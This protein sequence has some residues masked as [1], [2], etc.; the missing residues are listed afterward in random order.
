MSL[1]ARDA[2]IMVDPA[3]HIRF[4]N[5]AASELFGWSREEAMG[6]DLHDTVTPE[7]QR[8]R[9]NESMAEFFRSGEISPSST[10]AE[11]IAMRKD[12]TTFPIELSL[13]AIRRDEGYWAVGIVRDMTR[14]KHMEEELRQLATTDPLTGLA[15][16]RS[17]MQ[18]A[19]REMEQCRRYGHPL[20]LLMLDIDH[21]KQVNDTWG[22]DAGDEVLRAV[23][24]I[25]AESIREVDLCGRL[26][27]EEFAVLLP[28]TPSERALVV[29]ERIR[30]SI[31][32]AIIRTDGVTIPI[33]LSVGKAEMAL[34]DDVNNVIRRADEALYKA[35][36][37][38]R[39]R[40]ESA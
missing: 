18:Q 27:G 36:R 34:D 4:W 7:T 5:P 11:R 22:H 2:I 6:R 17:F 19:E 35:K 20:C 16:R 38:G 1:A 29:A 21:F 28:E 30:A 40:V 37:G 31:E 12:G 39:N 9:A 14:R 10:R 13:A 32:S 3:G 23:A 26:G 15:N 24:G 8:Q 25:V 33:T